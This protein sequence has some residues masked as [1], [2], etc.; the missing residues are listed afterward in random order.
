MPEKLFAEEDKL[1]KKIEKKYRE[2]LSDLY[3][4]KRGMKEKTSKISERAAWKPAE[5]A[6]DIEACLTEIKKPLGLGTS[7]KRKDMIKKTRS[8][9]EDT[10]KYRATLEVTA[11]YDLSEYKSTKKKKGSTNE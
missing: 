6:E 11:E 7:G 9:I 10:A 5:E 3:K 4:L 8:L 1:T 2:I